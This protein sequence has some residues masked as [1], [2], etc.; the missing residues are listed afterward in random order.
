MQIF[1]RVVEALEHVKT[2]EALAPGDFTS[3]H[4]DAWVD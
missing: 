2:N 3:W 4:I 1:E